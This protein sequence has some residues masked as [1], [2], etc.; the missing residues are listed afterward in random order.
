MVSISFAISEAIPYITKKAEGI[1]QITD[2]RRIVKTTAAHSSGPI[3][4]VDNLD[5]TIT[6]MIDIHAKIP[7]AMT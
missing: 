4:S 7:P 3:C 2:I 1:G 5:I 6:V